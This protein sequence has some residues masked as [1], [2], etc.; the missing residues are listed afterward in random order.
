[1][2][3]MSAYV[4]GR[5]FGSV[6]PKH[7]SC[8]STDDSCDDEEPDNDVTN[9]QSLNTSEEVQEESPQRTRR[10][11]RMPVKKQAP[12]DS[13]SP[14]KDNELT[15]EQKLVINKFDD[16]KKISQKIRP[17][18]TPSTTK[19]KYSIPAVSMRDGDI[20]F[21]LSLV[22]TMRKL[23]ESKRLKA[24]IDILTI[25][26]R[27]VDEA[28]PRAKKQKLAENRKHSGNLSE[29]ELKLEDCTEKNMENVWWT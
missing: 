16:L 10:S 3:F 6:T 27:Y 24:K 8:D 4:G 12:R 2:E 22:P 7:K 18:S 17:H 11:P 13:I 14:P 29:M 20:S 25:L 5:L 26:H 15:K 23:D 28:T 9:D 1:M 21:C 19:T